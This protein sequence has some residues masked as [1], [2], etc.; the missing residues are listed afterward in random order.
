MEI[1]APHLE[2]VMQSKAV[3]EPPHVPNESIN[4]VPVHREPLKAWGT[5]AVK[6]MDL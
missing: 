4:I 5:K 3:V 1:M 2:I 6:L